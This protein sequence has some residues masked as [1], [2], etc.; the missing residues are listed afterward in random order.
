[1]CTLGILLG[2]SERHP[3][4]I[5]ANRD[6]RLDRPSTAP[7]AWP[8]A[9][10]IAAGRDLVAGGTWLGVN[11]HGIVA[12]LTNLWTDGPADPTRRSRGEIV[13]GLLRSGSI[14]AARGFASG[15]RGGETNP[16]LAVCAAP[17]RGGFWIEGQDRIAIHPLEPGIHAFGNVVPDAAH[18]KLDRATRSLR[19]AF[20]SRGGEE[21]EDLRDA[22]AVAL[23]TH[24]GSRGPTES[25][26]VHTD[27][28]YGTVSSSILLLGRRTARGR[29][30][31]AAGP[32]CVTP[33][34]DHSAV[35]REL[36]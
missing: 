1:M 34:E 4:V 6:E 12:G 15:L 17:E 27:L 21:P 36:A 3:L 26:C 24:R 28:G 10:R 5:A 11:E 7:E 20:G 22:L 30:F 29:W 33:F 9:P 18:P 25:V 16:F 14:E 23:A 2:A 31:H 19:E 8:G 35:L 13:S 32:P